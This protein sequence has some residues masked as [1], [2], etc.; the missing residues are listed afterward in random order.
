VALAAGVS[1]QTVSNVLRDRGRLSDE[2]RAR[3][4]DAVERLRYA[5]HLGARSM[6][7]RRTAQFAHP[8]PPMEFDPGNTIAVEFV[9]ALVHAAGERDHHVLLTV[10][11][12]VHDD[13]DDL[14]RSGR[15]DA[16]IFANLE[17]DDPRIRAVAERGFPF[18]CFGRVDPGLPQNWVD[19]DNAAGI[20]RAVQRLHRAGH[21]DIGFF[22]YDGNSYWDFERIDGYRSAVTVAGLEPRMVLTAN[23]A[24]AIAAAATGLLAQQPA[25]TAIVCSSDRLAAAVYAAADRHG[26][27]IG[28][29][30]AV[31]GF[32]GSVVGRNLHPRLTTLAIPL[33]QIAGLVVD[34]VL[35]EIAAPTTDPGHMVELQMIDGDSG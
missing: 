10:T 28:R 9:Q 33:P 29:D 20:A 7:S 5:P 13:V 19:V 24:S 34:R 3:V 25:P 18:A 4:L 26:R 11:Q 27:L 32:D 21:T 23:D 14:I 15:I 17:P 30:L 12:H 8:M 35:R 22:G 6:R 1:R 31:T 2:T 16:F